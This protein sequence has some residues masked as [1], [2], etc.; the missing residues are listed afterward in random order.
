MFDPLRTTLADLR[1]DGT[2]RGLVEHGEDELVERKIA[3]PRAGFAPV[4]SA[5]ANT[6]GGW[7][8]LGV[9][10][11]DEAGAAS[12]TDF[13]PYGRAHLQDWLRDK[14]ANDLGAAPSF[15]AQ[16][17]DYERKR[18]GVVR[19][20][21][22]PVG[23][24]FMADGR[25]FVRENGRTVVVNS[26]EQLDALY[27]RA[28]VS[29]DDARQRLGTRGAAP[30]TEDALGMPRAGNALHGQ[31]MY[32]IV[33]ATPAQV[34]AAFQR[35]ATSR[36]AVEESVRVVDRVANLLPRGFRSDDARA[37]SHLARGGHSATIEID[38]R[39]WQGVQIA[40]DAAGVVGA[41]ISGTNHDNYFLL[42]DDEL[43]RHLTPLVSYLAGALETTDAL[44]PALVDFTLAG[45]T[46]ICPVI[47]GHHP[48]SFPP[49]SNWFET[50]AE[51]PIPASAQEVD[52]LVNGLIID[53]GRGAGIPIYSDD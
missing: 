15:R 2:L 49:G 41:R 3:E 30:V 20:P 21:H 24:H 36:T 19:V 45:A 50:S 29:L 31:T 10:D 1:D 32:L 7:L 43:R 22:S 5:L 53:L 52:Q 13:K 9:A 17:F 16:A 34:P 48:G 11:R 6:A 18:I 39:W 51:L 27:A 33:R 8:L 44:G 42:I 38:E 37:T 25:V 28:S 12:I 4:V 35:W 46:N 23:P 26:R 47:A 40:A 14:L